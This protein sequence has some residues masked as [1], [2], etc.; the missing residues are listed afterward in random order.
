MPERGVD[1]NAMAD[2]FWNLEFGL[3]VSAR[4]HDWRRASLG[5]VVTIIRGVTL[6][7]AVLAFLS[8]T[9][10]FSSP[11]GYGGT[12]AAGASVL[13]AIVTLVDLVFNLNGR[14]LSHESL[15][16]R[17][18]NLQAEM[19][20]HQSNWEPQIDKWEATATE[21][22]R[23]EPPTL[24]YVYAKSW[25]QGIEKHGAQRV[26]YFREIKLHHRLFGW[27]FSFDPTSFPPLE[28]EPATS[29]NAQP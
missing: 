3:E 9:D 2:R 18:V 7:G 5:R 26:G 15:Y 17:F 4:Y 13:I 25:N 24:W 29:G 21:I 19:K 28:G 6:V 22:R 20:A 8:L 10:W 1:A 27:L 14:A 16:R 11:G 12:V 23:D